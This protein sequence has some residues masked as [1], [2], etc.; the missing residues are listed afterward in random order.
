MVVFLKL[1]GDMKK[2]S[3]KVKAKE[4]LNVATLRRRNV[5]T[6]PASEL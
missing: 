3:I 2:K 4:Q 1:C 6:I 5:S